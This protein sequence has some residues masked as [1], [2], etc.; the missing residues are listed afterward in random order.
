MRE[1]RK[2]DETFGASRS[3]VRSWVDVPIYG[4]G[5]LRLASKRSVAG[6]IPNSVAQASFFLFVFGAERAVARQNQN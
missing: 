2:N 5:L 6:V 4:V 3:P 1:T